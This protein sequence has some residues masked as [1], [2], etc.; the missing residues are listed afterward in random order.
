MAHRTRERESNERGTFVQSSLAQIDTQ[1]K[2]S[3]AVLSFS[4]SLSFTRTHSHRVKSSRSEEGE[5]ECQCFVNRPAA[6]RCFVRPLDEHRTEEGIH[7]GC[8]RFSDARRLGKREALSPITVID[9]CWRTASLLRLARHPIT[10][11]VNERSSNR[12]YSSNTFLCYPLNMGDTNLT[13]IERHESPRSNRCRDSGVA[14]A[15][16]R[17]AQTT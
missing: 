7:G 1:T 5:R 4:L 9:C 10:D 15:H 8:L 12:R 14:S 2:Q 11:I 6:G 13:A 17:R 3:L 16:L